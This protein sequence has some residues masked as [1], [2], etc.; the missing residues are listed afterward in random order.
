MAEAAPLCWCCAVWGL[1]KRAICARTRLCTGC[2][3]TTRERCRR[4]HMAAALR[5]AGEP[6][7]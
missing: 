2:L 1:A 3:S 5:A 7:R 6:A 4:R